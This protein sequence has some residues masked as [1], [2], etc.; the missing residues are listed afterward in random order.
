MWK[1][2]AF[3]ASVFSSVLLLAAWWSWAQ[4]THTAEPPTKSMPITAIVD[5]KIY[6]MEA[7]EKPFQGVI[8]LQGKR[9]KAVGE[10]LAIPPGAR[11]IN[12]RGKVVTPG[13]SIANTRVG[14]VEIGLE[15]STRN[16][17]SH[18]RS[19]V[20]AHF[21]VRDGINH[22]SSLIPIA[23]IEGVTSVM[24]RPFGGFISGHSTLI[25]LHPSIEQRNVRKSVGM[26]ASIRAGH[27]AQRWLQLRKILS[28]TRFFLRHRSDYSMGNTRRLSLPYN[29][30][31]A[32][33]RVVQRHIPLILEVHR[34]SDI[35]AAIRFAREEQIRVVLVGVSEGWMVA[36]QL[37]RSY[38]PVILQPPSNLPL[39]FDRLASRYDN[40]ALLYKAGVLFALGARGGA[41]NIRSLRHEAGIYVANGLPKIEAIRALTYNLYEIF[42]LTRAYGSLE[43]GKVANLVL[44]SGDPLELSTRAERV[45]I[46]GEWMPMRSR[47][48]LLRERY[49]KLQ[50]L[51]RQAR[52]LQPPKPRLPS[53][54]TLQR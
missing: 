46:Q 39:R 15:G 11:V 6:S 10:R 33:S 3:V 52:P 42:H 27:S 36:K 24:V 28:D 5:A 47:Q 4:P 25:D 20:R 44:W 8:L 45:C 9:I 22:R 21:H 29:Q 30:L 54:P 35:L 49:R 26:H 31:V 41:H 34:S 48:T 18:T 1:K 7:G 51:F 37:A 43:K 23:R 2:I 17:R 12:A 53:A 50:T 40:A 19:N 38:I 32:M 13:L 16:D 14:I